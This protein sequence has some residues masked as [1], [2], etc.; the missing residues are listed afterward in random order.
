MI[1][2]LL[3]K[4]KSF[5]LGLLI[6]LAIPAYGQITVFNAD[7]T[8][9]LGDSAW[10]Y[11]TVSGLPFQRGTTGSHAGGITSYQFT[12]MNS[13]LYNNNTNISTTSPNIDLTGY[14]RLILSLDISIN[15]F[16]NDGMEI[17]YTNDNGVNW[18]KLGK[19]N[20]E[21]INWYNTS[22]SF[23]VSGATVNRSVW[24]GNSSG[25]FTASIDLPSQ[26]FDDQSAVHFR[27]NFDSNGSFQ[28]VGVAFDNFKITGYP[29]L[30]HNYS[31]CGSG[32]QEDLE[33]WLNAETLNS[34]SDGDL[35]SEWT[36]SA[37][38]V[39]VSNISAEWTNAKSTNGS[40]PTYHDNVANN[41]NFNPVVSF[42]G[43][44]S[45]FG[46]SGFFNKDIYLVIN[47]TATISAARA[48]EDVFLGDDY[49]SDDQNQ[50]ITGVSI[51]DTSARYGASKDIVAYNQ[52]AQGKYGK[53]IIHPTLV[54]DR[55]VIFNA[56]L[57]AAG[58]AMD[59]YLDGVD[60]GATLDPSLSE[61]VNLATFNNILNSRYWLGRSEFFGPSYTGDILEI[62]SY[63]ER[64]SDVDRKRI[65]S[66]LA[67]KFGIT[68]GLFPDTTL[69]L[70]HVPGFYVDSDGNDLWNSTLHPGFTYNVTG[71]GRDDCNVLNQKQ[72]KSIDP[73][74]FITIG[75]GDIYDTNHNNPNT[76]EDS[77]D[78]LMWGST[79]STLNALPS[80]LEVN[81]GPSLVTTFTDVTERTWKFKEISQN[82]NDIP[83]V[84]ISVS[85]AG[86]ASLPALVGN[87]AYVM[88]IADDKD[89]TTNIETKFLK[90]VGANQEA[91]HDFDNVKFVKFGVAHEVIEPRDIL[92]DGS[93]DY[94]AMDDEVEFTGNYSISAWVNTN[95]S[96]D[97]NTNKTIVSKRANGVDG[98][99][100][101]LTDDNRV[102]MTHNGVST[103]MS[104]TALSNNVW[105][106][107][108]FT[109]AGS[110]ANIYIDGVLDIT[111]DI[112]SPI[113]NDSRFCIGS[114]YVDKNTIVDNFS[115]SL[116]EI[117]IFS[118]SIT[119]RELRFIM[120]QELEKSGTGIKGSVIPET[121]T[122]NDISGM[123]W[124][125]L[126][127]YF[128]MNTY[129]GTH[130]NDASGNGHRGSLIQPDNFSINEQ[131]APLPYITTTDGNWNNDSSWV[132]GS[133]NFVPGA[134]RVI[135]GVNKVI[136]WNIVE[137]DHE[138]VADNKNY[139]FL[140][141]DVSSTGKLSTDNDRAIIVSH[142]LTLDGFI[143]LQGE[144]QLVQSRDSDLIPSTT[145]KIEIDQQGTSNTY[146]YNYWTSPVSIIT[147]GVNNNGFDIA[148][149]LK[150]GTLIDNPRDIT[151][152]G[153]G[154]RDGAPGTASVAATI[155]GRW[156]YKYG[157]T[158][159]NTYANWEYAGPTGI[160]LAGE[161]WTMKGT[162]ASGPIQNY[163]FVGKPNNGDINLD[164][165]N[166]ND[167]LIG[168]P[169]PS[170]LDAHDFISDNPDTDGTVYF[171]EHWGGDTHILA[172]YQGGY[173]TYNYSGGVGNATF[174][175]SNPDVNQGGVPTKLPKRY[176][177]VGQGF[178]VT[179]I[180]DGGQI[181]F[182]NGQREFEK[183]SDGES[184][185]VAA[186]GSD[187]ILSDGAIN[188]SRDTRLKIRLGFDSSNLIHR[189]L[190]LTV[191]SLTTY[192]VDRGYDGRLLDEQ[193]D[194]M[195]WIVNTD[196]LTIQGVPSIEN[197]AALPLFIKLK[198]D[199]NFSITIDDLLNVLPTQNIFIRDN[200]LNT[201]VN[202][203][204]G[205]YTSPV[206]TAG[207]YED[208]FSVVFTL[209]ETLSNELEQLDET[210][211]VV[212]TPNHVT[213]V[214]I[215]KPVEIEISDLYLINMLGQQ[216]R[217]YD[218]TG[219]MG[220][221]KLDVSQ[222]AS[223]NYLIKMNTNL[224]VVTKKVII[225]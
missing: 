205:D 109:Y 66:Y 59:L 125:D 225:K 23:I 120:N 55:P 176:I 58:D 97:S 130:L 145:G 197:G 90:T 178:F 21:A 72:A 149:V 40:E 166:G 202:L 35:V 9:G 200:V 189:Q 216:V 215:K 84:K 13:G 39:P 87:D 136:N 7:F 62:M 54:Y 44:K 3:N 113:N 192:Q 194:D 147:D 22:R 170:A 111:Q 20:D 148:S 181:R 57:N 89:F 47:P 104:N 80:P 133:V 65:E 163:I 207:T 49:T 37:T 79:I 164:I 201:Y 94:V 41:T 32:I 213:E 150:D 140:G 160:Q 28:N 131:T 182:R 187:P 196:K 11:Q 169:Y 15:T 114:R 70:P 139:K 199:S 103:I 74:T 95:G 82:A 99:H 14:E 68:L 180:N 144:S 183:E 179:G 24:Q 119:Q 188:T 159:S 212:F 43:T 211:L 18:H 8:T 93:D 161:G 67:M 135:N 64:K 78:F 138:M 100:F 76:F 81:L 106:Y 88:I 214:H 162:G 5:L 19:I 128:N 101:Y 157:N 117:R 123:L 51:N 73:N 12:G 191:D 158:T 151:F 195:S 34:L 165:D 167:Y 142:I 27:V 29:Q 118:N 154:V 105:R 17:E 107:V 184:I 198:D 46:K 56:R 116:D 69:G 110:T 155:S 85:T 10:T 175:T 210:D 108:T 127:A 186:P 77:G 42:D 1:K 171:W 2:K 220:V 30:N 193:I 53:A 126:E 121:I 221:L 219:K 217:T 60:L 52:G 112:L 208:R 174:G 71:I 141:L 222:I 45:M 33:L 4:K 146:D 143:D 224:G 129:I 168:N 31:A 83:E 50:D 16:T 48:T 156:L 102:A 124:T 98:Y 209:P 134:R 190:L 91:Y 218:M 223:G 203:M 75:L 86:L 92:F 26:A 206:L 38:L 61:E 115:G 137:V 173:A 177:P 122:R 153:T 36:N 6:I 63:S 132:N 204:N 152:T 172:S 185:F 96:N 25:W